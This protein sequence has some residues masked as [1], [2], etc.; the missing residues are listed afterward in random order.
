MPPAP[1]SA[2]ARPSAQTRLVLLVALSF[3]L[4][5]AAGAGWLYHRLNSSG[6]PP[7]EANPRLSDATLAVLRNLDSPVEIRYYALLDPASV[8][9][10]LAAFADRVDQLL[11]AY[12]SAASGKLTVTRLR[13]PSDAAATAAADDRIKAFNRDRG[14]ACYLGLAV[15]ASG[16]QKESLPQLAPEWEPALESDLTRTIVRV[17]SAKPPPPLSPLAI[18]PAD[19]SATAEVQRALPNWA[20]LSLQEATRLLREKSLAEFTATTEEMDA[21]IKAAEQRFLQAQT[22]DSEAAQQTAR[23]ELERLRGQQT[24]KLQQLAAR[25]KARIAAL[26]K[27]KQP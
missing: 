11:A 25:L 19:A 9:A 14:D 18:R 1:G 27:L 20:A 3:G 16:D 23:Q 4:G 17:L 10:A 5:L 6:A 22:T 15:I 2:S 8:P 13:T 7:A 21:Q 12:E 26:Q 24:E